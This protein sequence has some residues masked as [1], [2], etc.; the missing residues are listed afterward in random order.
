MAGWDRSTV[1]Y[2]DVL[3]KS[4]RQDS[5]GAIIE[6]CTT[7]FSDFRLE[8][9]FIYRQRPSI[10]FREQIRRNVSTQHY[11]IGV[12]TQHLYAFDEFLATQLSRNPQEIIACVR[13]SSTL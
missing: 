4:N 13:L 8:N 11:Y 10:M 6:K 5:E 12:D 2:A 3:S 1:S 9:H 7:F